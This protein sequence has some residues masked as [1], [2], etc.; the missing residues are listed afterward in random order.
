MKYI[1]MMNTMRA[2]AF[3]NGLTKIFRRISHL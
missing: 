2:T 1:L 3:P